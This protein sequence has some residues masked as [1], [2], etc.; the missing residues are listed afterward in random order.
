MGPGPMDLCLGDSLS[1]G[2]AALLHCMSIARVG[3]SSCAISHWVPAQY[4]DHVVISAGTNDPPGRCIEQLR[5]RLR[6]GNIVWVLPVNGAR[7]HVAGV[8]RASGDSVCSY[9]AGRGLGVHPSSYGPLAACV[10][11]RWGR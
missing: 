3:A 9:S 4:F 2:V 6:G 8:A 7:D 10:A 11:A 1:V 5:E